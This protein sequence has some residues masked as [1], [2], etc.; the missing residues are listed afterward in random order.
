MTDR[1]VGFAIEEEVVTAQKRSESTQ[2]V[3]IASLF[4]AFDAQRAG[5]S[6]PR[7]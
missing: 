5:Q 3:P 1:E 7:D 4:T 6:E 2:D